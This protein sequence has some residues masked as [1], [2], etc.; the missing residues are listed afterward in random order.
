[1]AQHAPAGITPYLP[2]EAYRT[3]KAHESQYHM[4][5]FTWAMIPESAED[6]K[7]C[8]GSGIV[9]MRL[10]ERGPFG[11]P[12]THKVVT[13]FDGD[14]HLRKGWYIV[15]ETMTFPC[16]K[17]QVTVKSPGPMKP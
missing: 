13:W 9:Y 8:G 15:K 17:C 1:M 4:P 14:G 10:A 11:S 2:T 7:N 5:V 6:C 12:T 16:P 3:A